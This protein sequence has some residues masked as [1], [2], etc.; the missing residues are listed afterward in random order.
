MRRL[1]G[2][3][4]LSLSFCLSACNNVPIAEDLS[5][6]EA[7]QIIALLASNGIYAV[8]SKDAGGKPKYDVEVNKSFY[9]QAKTIL[10]EKSLPNADR[11]SF[12]EIIEARGLL[13]NSREMEA[14]RLDHALALELEETLNSHPSI[15][16]AKVIVRSHSVPDASGRAASI[17]IKE[18]GDRSVSREE[19][20]S[21]A[22]KALP[23]I[24]LESI[25]INIS[26]EYIGGESFS[27]QGAENK[28]GKVISVPLTH[29]LFN[30]KVPESDYNAMV[31]VL[32][33]CFLVIAILGGLVGYW[34]GYF[35]NSKVMLENGLP[36]LNLR[37]PLRIDRVDKGPEI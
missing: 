9:T 4:I 31:M 10:V 36:D 26:K 12:S 25:V 11:Q 3:L 6:S 27:V 5:Q 14:L 21:V 34:Y 19:V 7:N 29:F 2:L 30:W 1:L 18:R 20:Q 24:A 37:A 16:N 17:V 15:V 35:K 32:I 33:I 28:E 22:S 13:P 23:G 8:S